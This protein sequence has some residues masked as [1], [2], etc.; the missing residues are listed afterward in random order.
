M[1][2]RSEPLPFR[3]ASPTVA[4]VTHEPETWLFPIG[5]MGMG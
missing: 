4:I 2:R 1:V 3:T 5:H